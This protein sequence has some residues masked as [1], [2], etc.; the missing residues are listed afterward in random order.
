MTDSIPVTELPYDSESEKA[1]IDYLKDKIIIPV[2][3]QNKVF[4]LVA[5][6]DGSGDSGC[7]TNIYLKFQDYVTESA[8]K[9]IYESVKIITYEQDYSNGTYSKVF[10]E[11]E[12]VFKDVLFS[13]F[14]LY[15]SL[16]E[17]GWENNEGAFG[18]FTLKLKDKILDLDF[19]Q[20]IMSE[21]HRAYQF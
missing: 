20:R 5:D 13:L 4:E 12:L 8:N 14:Y 17:G 19:N 9:F 21:D 10:L 2:L 3:E 7:I 11:Q 15:L 1:Y 6:F 16:V 18:E